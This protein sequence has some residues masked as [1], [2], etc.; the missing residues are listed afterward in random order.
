MKNIIN[1]FIEWLT[2]Y[3]HQVK[4]IL[5]L[6]FVGHIVMDVLFALFLLII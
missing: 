5:K 2:P 6:G 4:K 1:R 3:A